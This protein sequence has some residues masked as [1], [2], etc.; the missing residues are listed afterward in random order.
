MLG[1][2][3]VINLLLYKFIMRVLNEAKLSEDFITGG[4]LFQSFAD[5]TKY[6]SLK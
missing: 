5:L 2:S 6:D 3:Y 1:S 4:R